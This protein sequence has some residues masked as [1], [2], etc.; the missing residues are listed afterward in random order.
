M[1]YRT[2]ILS[3]QPTDEDEFGSH[4]RIANSL[5]EIIINETGGKTIGLVGTWGSGKSTIISVLQKLIQSNKEVNENIKFIV[6]D[7]WAHEG[8]PLRRSFLERLTISLA[9]WTHNKKRW[10]EERLSELK[11]QKKSV[12]ISGGSLLS[13]WGGAVLLSFFAIPFGMEFFKLW[14]TYWNIEHLI[15]SII[16]GLF[17]IWTILLAWAC[18]SKN[19]NELFLILINKKID[20]QS[21]VTEDEFEPT[22][23]EFEKYY[24]ELMNECI[25]NHPNGKICIVIENLDRILHTDAIKL[26][27]TLKPFLQSDSED[28]IWKKYIYY[29]IPFDD[30]G[31][32]KIWNNNCDDVAKEFLEKLFQIR[33]YTPIQITSD[34]QKF[35]SKQIKDA[36]IGVDE[37]TN[38]RLKRIFQINIYQTEKHPTPRHIKV[39]INQLVGVYRQW[40]EDILLEHQALFVALR[41]YKSVNNLD[42]LKEYLKNKTIPT[43]YCD[44]LKLQ[45][46]LA[47]MLLNIPPEKAQQVWLEPEITS[48]LTGANKKFFSEEN[49]NI[50]LN[51][52]IET[53]LDSQVDDWLMKDPNLLLNAIISLEGSQFIHPFN[54]MVSDLGKITSWQFINEVYGELI[55]R[56][57]NAKSFEDIIKQIIPQ[58]GI[59]SKLDDPANQNKSKYYLNGLYAFIKNY[60]KDRD[61][62]CLKDFSIRSDF[63]TYCIV[64]SDAFNLFNEPFFL[65]MMRPHTKKRKEIASAFIK[66]I[67]ESVFNLSISQAFQVFVEYAD[68]NELHDDIITSVLSFISNNVQLNQEQQFHYARLL[69]IFRKLHNNPKDNVRT[70]LRDK[71]ISNWIYHHLYYANQQNVKPALAI[72]ITLILDDVESKYSSNPGGMTQQGY[73]YYI[74]QLRNKISSDEDLRKLI[75]KEIIS[76][77]LI[78]TI[79]ENGQKEDP[80]HKHI[81]DSIITCLLSDKTNHILI[82]IKT[83][84]YQYS[85]FN[86]ISPNDTHELIKSSTERG[87]IEFETT[88]EFNTDY[89]NQYLTMLETKSGIESKSFRDWITAGIVNADKDTWTENLSIESPFRK[90]V[91]IVK[92]DLQGKLTDSLYSFLNERISQIIQDPSIINESNINKYENL[93]ELLDSNH[94]ITLKKNCID[95]AFL[96]N[97]DNTLN[98]YFDSFLFLTEDKKLLVQKS[99]DFVRRMFPKAIDGKLKLSIVDKLLINVPNIWIKAE[100]E[101]KQ[102]FLEKLK[103]IESKDKK[104]VADKLFKTIGAI[105]N[106]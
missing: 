99:D 20:S 44:E 9:D 54:R 63:K 100:S 42:K 10:T 103:T 25:T 18:N 86:K 36:F 41:Y 87:L 94:K 73:N 38:Y 4:T 76:N 90:L 6:F 2:K 11:K 84:S 62:D 17:P 97:D 48:A 78:S 93:I 55:A 66:N 82:P 28:A 46:D 68:I 22:S 61:A 24:E 104:E 96:I 101:S 89:C 29:I 80:L 43:N 60:L 92:I 23:I 3:D 21:K 5:K 85:Y 53:F 106:K 45:A 37:D 39:F 59:V 1:K 69:M 72:W 65:K 7:V 56:L 67:E 14:T 57:A 51:T 40:G 49:S 47:G 50:D 8:D 58:L 12:T 15:F 77:N 83:V 71:F 16:L 13:I 52:L 27:A 31:F 34:W 26:I 91:D 102:V 74:N 19:I 81:I 32:S 30:N 33:M 35:F 88:I 64:T 98:S 75:V 105:E 79:S 95:L 70:I